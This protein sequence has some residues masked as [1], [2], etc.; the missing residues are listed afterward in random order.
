[1][2][3]AK[4]GDTITV[5]YTGTFEDGKVFD[6]SRQRDPMEFTIGQGS[7]I[8]GFEQAVVGM[9][10]GESKTVTLPPEQAYGTYDDQKVQ[11][12]ERKQMPPDLKVE[13]GQRLEV[14][15]QGG[16]TGIVSVKELTDSTVTLDANHPLAGQTLIFD[17]EL[18]AIG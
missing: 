4:D 18:I 14:R 16:Q 7:L 13:V 17:I 12:I 5:H 2:A 3:Q 11:V 6:T 8:S 10:P 1:M 9:A 15:G